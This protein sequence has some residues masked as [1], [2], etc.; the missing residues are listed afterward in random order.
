MEKNNSIIADTSALFSLIVQ[1]DSNNQ[2]ALAISSHIREVHGFLF[3]PSDVFTETLNVFGRKFGH[4]EA[5]FV[6]DKLLDPKAF[7]ILETESALRTAALALFRK[8][9]NSVSFT[10]CVVMATA[11]GLQTSEVFGFD[12]VFAK[13][14]YHL[15]EVV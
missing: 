8:Q 5:G 4:K 12:E 7:H 13:N 2:K 15:P 10:D 3:I 11:D 9:P 1:S 14:G 6:A